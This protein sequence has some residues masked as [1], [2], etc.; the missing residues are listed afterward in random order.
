LNFAPPE[1]GGEPGSLRAR[2][3]GAKYAAASWGR[4]GLDA[5]LG[6]AGRVRQSVSSRDEA[7]QSAAELMEVARRATTRLQSLGLRVVSRVADGAAY[8]SS[9]DEDVE[10]ARLLVGRLEQLFSTADDRLRRDA[11]LMKVTWEVL[12]IDA[13]DAFAR[14]E[15]SRAV[16]A[17]KAAQATELHL[18]QLR[19]HN[20]ARDKPAAT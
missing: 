19:L 18:Q 20:G 8:V 9:D 12:Q 17:Q 15:A 7:G 1:D 3:A 5:S 14:G 13:F 6:A 2:L 11:P 16:V 10:K 4:W